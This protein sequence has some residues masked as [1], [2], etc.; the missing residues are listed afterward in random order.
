MPSVREMRTFARTVPGSTDA[1]ACSFHDGFELSCTCMPENWKELYARF[2][3]ADAQTR[4]DFVTDL[5]AG[6]YR[7][8]W[9]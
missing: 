2:V 9:K 7:D 4:L 8:R 3:S 6:K 1:M 5:K